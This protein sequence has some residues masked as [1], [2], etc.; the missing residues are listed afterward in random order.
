MAAVGGV[1]LIQIPVDTFEED[2]RLRHGAP[3][4]SPLTAPTITV[5]RPSQPS[6]IELDAVGTYLQAPSADFNHLQVTLPPLRRHMVLE[7]VSEQSKR[8]AER[9][10]ESNRQA[11]QTGIEIA[12]KNFFIKLIATCVSLVVLGIAI[13]AVVGTLGAAAPMAI[14]FIAVMGVVTAIAIADM[15]CALADWQL[16][17]HGYS[18]LACGTC[19]IA[20]GIWGIF[21]LCGWRNE[22][23]IA[24]AKVIAI[25]IKILIT[26]GTLW[27]AEASPELLVDPQAVG[28][29]LGTIAEECSKLYFQVEDAEKAHQEWFEKAVM[30]AEQAKEKR[31]GKEFIEG[32][33]KSQLSVQEKFEDRIKVRVRKEYQ[34]AVSAKE[35]LDSARTQL[36]DIEQAI[37]QAKMVLGSEVVVAM[38]DVVQREVELPDDADLSER[39]DAQLQL[40]RF[41]VKEVSLK[42]YLDEIA[43]M[44]H[45]VERLREQHIESLTEAHRKKVRHCRN[46]FLGK[47]LNTPLSLLGVAGAAAITGA[48]MG[49]ATPLA[50]FMIGIFSFSIG[51]AFAAYKNWQQMKKEGEELQFGSDFIANEMYYIL[52]S[53]EVDEEKLI[54]L[55]ENTS[56]VLRLIFTLG[57]L[58]PKRKALN[59]VEQ[60][61]L[62]TSHIEPVTGAASERLEDSSDV[63]QTQLSTLKLE[64]QFSIV[65]EAIRDQQIIFTAYNGEMERIKHQG[66]HN[67]TMAYKHKLLAQMETEHIQRQLTE[68]RTE[69]QQLAEQ[70][71][72]QVL[73]YIESDEVRELLMQTMKASLAGGQPG[74]EVRDKGGLRVPLVP[75]YHLRTTAI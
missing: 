20:N 63:A 38:E 49:A 32:L 6:N 7:K 35:T 23:S 52:R 40:G 73:K 3:T 48:T 64:T 26:I 60:L 74:P 46:T 1:E 4:S 10:E 25:V 41:N 36:E 16:K 66:Q 29:T 31:R 54:K 21:Y 27:A 2:P 44:S 8:N 56:V 65:K 39:A 37:A 43:E 22:K 59:A 72:L 34:L 70:Q 58:W 24:T 53:E 13:G 71:Q 57:S 11:M 75:P 50:L 33:V 30:D 47:L 42:P 62:V 18:G 69:F 17:S 51:D 19:S 15:F 9:A 55:S 67:L 5:T 45:R 68:L 61:E 28:G 12:K 14:P